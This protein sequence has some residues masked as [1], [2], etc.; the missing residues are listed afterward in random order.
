MDCINDHVRVLGA[1]RRR[2]VRQLLT[3]S[4]LLSIAGGA[5]GLVLGAAILLAMIANTYLVRLRGAGRLQSRS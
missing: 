1:D 4:L 5:L 3:E 2:L